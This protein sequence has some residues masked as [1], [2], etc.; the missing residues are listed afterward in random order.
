MVFNA[1]RM[2]ALFDEQEHD[3]S[4]DHDDHVDEPTG[5]EQSLEELEFIR[6][7][8]AAAQAGDVGKLARLLSNK[9]LNVLHSD[10]T[11]DGSTGYTPLHYAAR[12]G[13]LRC[14]EL[15]ISHDADVNARTASGGATPLHRAA[16]QGHTEVAAALIAARADLTIVDSDGSTVLHKAAE[17]GRTDT[18]DLLLRERPSLA[19]V[20]D[21]KG[22]TP[23]ESAFA[24]ERQASAGV[25]NEPTT[26]SGYT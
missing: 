18:F 19:S 1:A 13:Q 12:A 15:L 20:R 14:V 6:S 23:Q 26:A 17:E 9:R 25:G 11:T 16:H 5:V 22:R 7:A 8:C 4:H 24:R 10:G 21:R 2:Q 3:H